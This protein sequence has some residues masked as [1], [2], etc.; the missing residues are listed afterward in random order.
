[1]N[2]LI[3]GDVV[4]SPGRG[5]LKKALPVVFERHE[6]DYCIANAE[7]AAGGFGVTK[8]VCD[9][10]LDAGIDC[11]TSGNHIWDK[12]EIVG[13]VDLIPQLLRPLNYPDGQPGRG[14]HVGKGKRSG[15]PVATLNLS[16][17]VFMHG[18]IDDPFRMGSEA[19]KRLRKEARIVIVDVHGEA[20]SEKTAL[21]HHFDGEV[22]AV[23]GTHTHVPTCDHRILPKG[24][25]YCTD[26]GMTGP[27]D[28]VIGVEKDAVLQRF[29]TGMRTRFETAKGDPRFAAAVVSADPETGLARS[30][31]RMLLTADD[32]KKL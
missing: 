2:I 16:C 3:I 25:A 5:I 14:D 1:M 12:K 10:L 9:E 30:I 19:V 7:N 23:V 24:T 20:S 21:G 17:R 13:V 22:A 31:E 15:I 18:S 11:L 4:G 6:V 8:D 28:S 26:L 29:L 32:L 27:Y